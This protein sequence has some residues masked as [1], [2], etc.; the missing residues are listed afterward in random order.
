MALLQIHIDDNL[1]S[2]AREVAEG[3]EP[4]FLQLSACF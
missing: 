2:Q 1:A 3:M 4:I